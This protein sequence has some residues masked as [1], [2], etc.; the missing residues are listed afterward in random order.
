MELEGQNLLVGEITNVLLG[1]YDFRELAKKSVELAVRKLKKQNLVGAGIFRV[2]EQNNLLYAYAYAVNHQRLIEKIMPHSVFSGLNISLSE[3][4]NLL[5]RT[6]VNSQVQYSKRASEFSKGSVPTMIADKAQKLSGG[7]SGIAFPIRLRSG[8]TAGAILLAF[9]KEDINAQQIS[10]F[11]TFAKQLGLA[12]S[13]VFAF[14]KLMAKYKKSVEQNSLSTLDQDIPNLKF[15]LRLS[16]RQSDVLKRLAR[17]RG[18][19]Q[20]EVIREW[21]DNQ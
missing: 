19:T 2:H 11:E 18:K 6:V 7:K 10:L 8:K 16:S 4:D 12:F 17:E 13:N 20:A 3:T 9:D 14:E 15:T 1:T 5:V 21:L